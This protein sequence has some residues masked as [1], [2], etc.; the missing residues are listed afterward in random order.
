M[1]RRKEPGGHPHESGQ[2]RLNLSP[3]AIRQSA[4]SGPDQA[5]SGRGPA[6]AG[7]SAPRTKN[8]DRPR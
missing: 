3:P 7:A 8:L 6:S 2:L 4:T 1:A 5:P